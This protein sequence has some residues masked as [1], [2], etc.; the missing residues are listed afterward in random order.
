MS[1]QQA[2]FRK[3]CRRVL[4]GCMGSRI[5]VDVRALGATKSERQRTAIALVPRQTG[6]KSPRRLVALLS[7]YF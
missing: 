5:F 2:T 4:L 6:D 7:P 1:I 3:D